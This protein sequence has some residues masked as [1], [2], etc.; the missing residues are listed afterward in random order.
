MEPAASSGPASP[1]R[2]TSKSVR[3]LAAALQAMSHVVSRQ[4]VAELLA[5]AGYRL[6]ATA[7]PGKTL[8]A[9]TAT[10]SFATSTSKS[11]GPSGTSA[12]GLRREY[13]EEG[14]RVLAAC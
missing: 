12:W 3:Q 7:R 1:L 14:T 5:A 9:R 6:Q 11:V 13:K 10:P 4:L 8:S 2:R